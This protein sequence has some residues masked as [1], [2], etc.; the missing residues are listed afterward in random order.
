MVKRNILFLNERPFNPILGGIERVTDVITKALLAKGQYSVYYLC[1][2][3]NDNDKDYLNYDFP[4]ILY[5]L[6]ENGLFASEK[7]IQFYRDLLNNLNIDI[8]I[9]QRGLNGGFNKILPI[10]N[11]KK[12][13]VLSDIVVATDDMRI[14]NCVKT[15]GGKVR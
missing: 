3:I 1:G 15:F 13:S 14:A 5:T 2:K 7:N 12:I 4:T 9:N 8:V 11:V 6:P 10:G